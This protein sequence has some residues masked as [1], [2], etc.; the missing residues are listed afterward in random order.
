MKPR[1]PDSSVTSAT[2]ETGRISCCGLVFF[3]VPGTCG[4]DCEEGGVIVWSL[5][6]NSISGKVYHYQIIAQK[7]VPDQG[8]T[9]S[10][11]SS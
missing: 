1:T 3:L 4:Q 2:V 5:C 9:Y 7:E 8:R 6:M 10:L 11:S